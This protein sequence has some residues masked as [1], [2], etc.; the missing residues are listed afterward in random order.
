MAINRICVHAGAVKTYRIK[1]AKRTST[2][3]SV[4][5]ANVHYTR[6]KQYNILLLMLS[7]K[8]SR[9]CK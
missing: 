4:I 9:I 3:Q 1:L 7:A 6:R 5:G 2:L 8:N